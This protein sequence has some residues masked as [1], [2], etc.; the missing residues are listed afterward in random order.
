MILRF[1]IVEKLKVSGMTQ[2]VIDT[3]L[4]GSNIRIQGPN[5]QIKFVT[6]LQLKLTNYFAYLRVPKHAYHWTNR[7][8]VSRF[9]VH[10]DHG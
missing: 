9:L 1:V 6:C 3:Y 4:L 10:F 2:C 5:H 7:K 8:E